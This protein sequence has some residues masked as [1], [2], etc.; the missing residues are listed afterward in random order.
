MKVGMYHAEK[1]PVNGTLASM[2]I[3]KIATA[4]GISPKRGYPEHH[5][6]KNVAANQ[7]I[8]YLPRQQAAPG[9]NSLRPATPH[10][11]LQRKVKQPRCAGDKKACADCQNEEAERIQAGREVP[12]AQPQRDLEHKNKQSKAECAFAI[13]ASLTIVPARQIHGSQQRK[14]KQARCEDAAKFPS[15]RVIL[16]LH[17]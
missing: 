13:G 7:R 2:L 14:D 3:V 4:K 9:N 12:A 15:G 5:A 10:P 11:R 17:S 8:A 16:A 6:K 1:S